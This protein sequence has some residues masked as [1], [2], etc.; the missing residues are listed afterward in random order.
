MVW[1]LASKKLLICFRCHLNCDILQI[2]SDIISHG[3]A[4]QDILFNYLSAILN[5]MLNVT[6][7][8]SNIDFQFSRTT[9]L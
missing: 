9:F 7:S 1:S 5:S 4:E 2:V 3:C 6:K 8:R